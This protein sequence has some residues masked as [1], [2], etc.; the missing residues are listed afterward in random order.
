MSQ[1]LRAVASV[2]LLGAVVPAGTAYHLSAGADDSLLVGPGEARGRPSVDDAMWRRGIGV[3]CSDRS[4]DAA[5]TIDGPTWLVDGDPWCGRLVYNREVPDFTVH[6]SPDQSYHTGALPGPARELSFDVVMTSYVGTYGFETCLPW[7]ADGSGRGLEAYK[8]AHM[9]TAEVDLTDDEER[10]GAADRGW[11]R[12]NLGLRLPHAGAVASGLVGYHSGDGWTAAAMDTSFVGFLQ[13]A[14][15]DPVDDRRLEAW[16]LDLKEEGIL[17]PDAQARICGYTPGADLHHRD[18]ASRSC[19][20]AFSWVGEDDTVGSL[21]GY[22]GPCET[23]AYLCGV[24]TPGWYA[25]LGC[26]AITGV[27]TTPGGGRTYGAPGTVPTLDRRPVDTSL[28]PDR[29]TD[30]T[31]GYRL[32]HFVVAPTASACDAHVE[33]GFWFDIG[34]LDAG[35]IPYLAHDLDVH[36]PAGEGLNLDQTD[37]LEQLAIQETRDTLAGLGEVGE[38]GVSLAWREHRREPN[39]EPQA[40]PLE[41]TT[42]T[43]VRVDRSVAAECL[44]LAS[45]AETPTTVDP[46]LDVIDG[47]AV[48]DATETTSDDRIDP[49][50]GELGG[51][52]LSS[53]RSP[54]ADPDATN[55]PGPASLR[56][57]GKVGVFADKDDDGRYLGQPAGRLWEGWEEIGAY[58]MFW[59]LWLDEDHWPGSGIGCR[60]AD[61]VANEQAGKPGGSA[62][63][64]TEMMVQAGY[65]ARTGL[66]AAVYQS[67]PAVW[68]DTRTGER[69]LVGDQGR[70]GVTVLMSQGLH[71]LYNGTEQTRPDPW[72][73]STIRGI[74][75]ELTTYATD[76]LGHPAPELFI[77]SRDRAGQGSGTSDFVP[78][79]GQATGGFQ[80]AWRFSHACPGPLGC[81]GDTLVT[82]YLRQGGPEHLGQAPPWTWLEPF[83]PEGQGAYDWEGQAVWVDVDPLDGDPTRSR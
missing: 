56:I 37:T 64:L 21:E 68:E 78:Q 39:A 27:C 45:T 30:S 71:R 55:R 32:W 12:Y 7:C 33:P 42:G 53:A 31:L 72:T 44:A 6:S 52:A 1:I 83:T 25:H 22:G 66:L 16:V 19:E 65:E 51:Y 79:C 5:S 57:E 59:D 3:G 17:H 67:Q 10:V 15:G 81:Q 77:P 49:L 73:V 8:A 34:G 82:A 20:V 69:H 63:T 29:P 58:P 70:G 50:E 75:Q 2:L 14:L 41:E 74:I 46:W 48:L 35:S 38:A 13:D 80:S 76:G 61:H 60:P 28:V 62:P 23:P 36:T 26:Q 47:R 24:N 54:G 40:N 43:H 9:A 11:Q 18:R 4:N